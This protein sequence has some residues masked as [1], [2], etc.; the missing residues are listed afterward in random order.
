MC[1]SERRATVAAP[2]T[3]AGFVRGAQCFFVPTMSRS[4]GLHVRAPYAQLASLVLDQFND[5]A[6]DRQPRDS[7]TLLNN[8]MLIKVRLQVV[9]VCYRK[10]AVGS[11]A[12]VSPVATLV[13]WK[14]Y[15]S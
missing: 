1:C 8:P 4:P 5:P 14:A 6:P 10:L 15:W 11:G 13:G 7:R 12:E 2:R 9:E 3:V